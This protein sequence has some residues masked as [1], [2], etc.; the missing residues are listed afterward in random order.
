MR[1]GLPTQKTCSTAG[2]LCI[3]YPNAI[4]WAEVPVS[5][6]VLS[7]QHTPSP[8]V[9]QC[10][11]I[12]TEAVGERETSQGKRSL[13]CACLGLLCSVCEG[14]VRG[15]TRHKKPPTGHAT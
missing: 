3:M 4:S 15:D 7:T 8:A 9:V 1:V 14:L 11:V 2:P 5:L 12:H 10:L 13:G 6:P